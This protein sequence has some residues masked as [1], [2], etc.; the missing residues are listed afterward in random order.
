MRGLM[1]LAAALGV[2]ALPAAS[3]AASYCQTPL[4]G[5]LRVHEVS[6]RGG[7]KVVRRYAV[8]AQARGPRIQVNGYLCNS[9]GDTIRCRRG[10]ARIYYH[11]GF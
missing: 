2:L 10:P 11:G 9:R 3:H 5:V 1:V 4:P 6:C 8:K 7:E